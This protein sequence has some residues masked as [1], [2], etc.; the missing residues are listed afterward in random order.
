MKKVP[1]DVTFY[2][3]S[4]CNLGRVSRIIRSFLLGSN[5]RPPAP[6]AGAYQYFKIFTCK[7]SEQGVIAAPII[8]K[9][10]FCISCIGDHVL[11]TLKKQLKSWVRIHQFQLAIILKISFK[12]K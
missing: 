6:K 12:K 11:V 10:C 5:L 1:V 3:K 7:I 9:I 4:L 2:F 8:S